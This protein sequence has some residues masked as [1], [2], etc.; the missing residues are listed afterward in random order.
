MIN[1]GNLNATTYELNGTV[2][3][4]WDDVDTNISINFGAN[5]S[6]YPNDIIPWRVSNEGILQVE[7]EAL[8]NQ[9][10]FNDSGTINTTTND[11]I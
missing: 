10:W 6:D 1:V 4:D 3:D 9:F 2:I 7:V 8:A 5:E 11:K